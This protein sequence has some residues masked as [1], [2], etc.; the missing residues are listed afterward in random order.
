MIKYLILV[1]ERFL[2]PIWWS[3]EAPAYR[4]GRQMYY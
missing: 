2:H 3:L 1:N 4:M